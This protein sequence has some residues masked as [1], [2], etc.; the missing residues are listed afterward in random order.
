MVTRNGQFLFHLIRS[1][2]GLA[3]RTACWLLFNKVWTNR[4]CLLLSSIRDRHPARLETKG[5]K[6]SA[7]CGHILGRSALRLQN[8]RDMALTW[9]NVPPNRDA[10]LSS[11]AEATARSTRSQTAS[12][13]QVWTLSLGVPSGTGG[14][15]RRTLGLPLTNREAA[16]ALRV[17]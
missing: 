10:N 5:R 7:I 14:D 2:Y 17:R 11:P 1:S 9:Q 4:L 6:Q 13:F 15:F 3:K 12:C 16:V 8:V